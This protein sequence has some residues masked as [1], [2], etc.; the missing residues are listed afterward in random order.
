MLQEILNEELLVIK[1]NYANK[2]MFKDY[3]KFVKNAT[4]PNPSHQLKSYITVHF[5]KKTHSV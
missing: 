2:L 1:L 3:Y 4:E 5:R